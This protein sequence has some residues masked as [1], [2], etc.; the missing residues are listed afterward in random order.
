M[1]VVAAVELDDLVAA[2]EAAG[3]PDGRHRRLRAGVAH[4]HLFHAGDCVH[5]QVGHLHFVG[6]RYAEARP[7]VGGVFHRLDDARRGVAMDRRTPGADV[8]D[9][10]IA[11]DVADLGAAGV[12]DE[13]GIASD[14]AKGADGGIDAAGNMLQGGFEEFL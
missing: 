11:V 1:S 6:I 8:I 9:V 4:A 5:H 2:G 12:I 7:V 10:F 14:G 13:E 3:Q